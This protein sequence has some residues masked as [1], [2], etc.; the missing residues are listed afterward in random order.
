METGSL[1]QLRPLFSRIASMM[2]KNFIQGAEEPRA[3][4]NEHDG[5]SAILKHTANII[6][7][8]QIVHQMLNH[9][10]TDDGVKFLFRWIR[11]A[12]LPV[13]ISHTHVRTVQAGVLEI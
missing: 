13:R 3:A 6:Q 1:R 7:S 11:F 4:R 8:S 12:L 10:Q 9:V 2:A 5:A